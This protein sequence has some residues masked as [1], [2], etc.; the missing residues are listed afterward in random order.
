VLASWGE[1]VRGATGAAAQHSPDV[2]TGVFPN[3]PER[4]VRHT[5]LL[6]RDLAATERA[7]AMPATT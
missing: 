1:D 3:E 4:A 6:E 5:A 2:P 7:D